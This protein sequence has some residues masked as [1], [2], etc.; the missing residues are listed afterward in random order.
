M[1]TRRA[2]SLERQITQ[3]LQD[4]DRLSGDI[5][6]IGETDEIIHTFDDGYEE[7]VLPYHSDLKTPLRIL[8][9]HPGYIAGGCFKDLFN[10][11]K[12]KDYDI[13]FLNQEDFDRTL[14]FYQEHSDASLLYENENCIAFYMS[15]Y[16]YENYTVELIK[17]KFGKPSEII[18]DFD[19]D[20]THYSLFL[21]DLGL[22]HSYR[23]VNV[24]ENIKKKKFSIRRNA[25]ASNEMFFERLG[26]YMAYGYE[27]D[28]NDYSLV[29]EVLSNYF[30]GDD[31]RQK[32]ISKKDGEFFIKKLALFKTYV[33]LNDNG[34][35]SK[36]IIIRNSIKEFLLSITDPG[37]NLDVLLEFWGS[38]LNSVYYKALVSVENKDKNAI[39]SFDRNKKNALYYNWRILKFLEDN[40]SLFTLKE[41]QAILFFI[42][43]TRD[44]ERGHFILA[45]NKS[46]REIFHEN[47]VEGPQPKAFANFLSRFINDFEGDYR[48]TSSSFSTENIISSSD[49]PMN[50]ISDLFG[51]KCDDEKDKNYASTL[52]AFKNDY[53]RMFSKEEKF[54]F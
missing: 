1:E 46:N 15:S 36:Q 52:R 17:N 43:F 45:K 26:R 50:I 47:F 53:K 30:E 54:P 44:D 21:D 34:S 29:K 5:Y 35:Y 31:N 18:K 48:F 38:I 4:L 49:L 12:P 22:I 8:Y 28:I 37:Y 19:I 13:Y 9:S 24:L 20:I 23:K 32:Y 27:L 6:P 7:A 39:V 3:I 25:Q 11:K 14:K 33:S 10:F 2:F 41:I 51:E 16:K 42:Y 40:L